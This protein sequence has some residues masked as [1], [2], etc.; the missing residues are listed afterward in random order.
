[1][2]KLLLV[3]DEE[4]VRE[5]LVEEIDWE[6]LGFQVVDTAENGMEATELFEKHI[7]DVVVTDIQMPFMD[8]LQLAG[9]IREHYRA[10]KIIILTGYD[11]FEYAQKA[12]KLQIDE[13]LLKPFSSQDLVE[14]VLKVKRQIDDEAAE[15]ENIHVLMEHYRKSIPVLR[16]L[17]LSQLVSR[18]M[19]SEEIREKSGSYGV[20]M[21][22]QGFMAS[23]LRIDYVHHYAVLQEEGEEG[24]ASVSLK[25]SEDRYLQLFAVLNIADE[26]CRR[27]SGFHVFIH[28]ED[29]VLLAALEEKDA[30]LAAQQTLAVLDEIR[31]NVYKYLN[32]T[33]TIGAGT[34]CPYPSEIHQSYRKAV[35]AL[36]Y[37]LILGNDR[38][39]WIGDVETERN[40][41]LVFDEFKEQSLIRC[42]KVGTAEE[43]EELIGKMFGGIPIPQ[44]SVQDCQVYLMEIL[45]CIMKVAKEFGVELEE[46]FGEGAHPFA[47]VY[48]YNNLQEVQQWMGAICLKLMNSIAQGRQSG[49]N[50]LV[51]NAKEYIRLHFRESDISIH[52][53]CQHLHISTGYFSS[54][55]KKEVKM[56]FVNYLLQIRMET[57][58]EMLRSTDLKTFEIAEAVGFTDPNYFSFCFRK[59]FGISP[60]S[61]RSGS[62]GAVND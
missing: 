25:H 15:K 13:F 35:E 47:E 62:G 17:F 28:M 44:L 45:A 29:C 19:P 2:Y 36:D 8:G 48:K 7:P 58:K 32:L 33:M 16:E 52:R 34:V 41:S 1:M 26:I 24:G 12:I 14:V 18:S 57:A 38:V 6:S 5:G 40:E 54:I 53:V 37:R 59:K 46:L 22:G 55:F 23:V 61:Y 42:M 56:T 51:E 49:Y 4:D 11:E 60:K 21:D 30:A 43:L 9:W 27:V 50:Q 20:N 10:T 3:E 39:I 31:I